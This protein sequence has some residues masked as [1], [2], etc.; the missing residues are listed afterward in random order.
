MK[1]SA[2]FA[3]AFVLTLGLAQCKKEQPNAQI[4]EGETVH[5]TVNVNN[6]G[7]RADVNTSTGHITFNDN[8][9]LYVG[10]N[11]AYVGTLDYSTS[12]SKFIGNIPLTEAAT[13]QKLHF[14][15]LGGGAA[16]QV[17][18]TQQYTVDI[19]D[20]TSNY[21]VI[22]YGT[23]TQ[24]YSASLNSYTTTLLNQCALVEFTT[25]EIPTT[26]AVSISGMKNKVTVDFNGNTLTPS[27]ERGTITL[28]NTESAISRWA[29]LLPDEEEVTSTASADGYNDSESFTVPAVNPN[30]YLAGESAVSISLTAAPST[31][32]GAINGLFSVSATQQVY[33]SKGNLQYIG[34][35]ATP[36]WQFAENQWDYLGTTTNQ[37]SADQNVDRDLF[38]WG[39]SGYNHGATAYQPWSTSKTNSDYY[40]YGSYTYNLY[41]QTGQADWGYNAISNGG[42]TENS[43]WRTLTQPEWDYV[44]NTRTTTSGIRYAK[45]RVNGKNG[46]IL[47]PDDWDA[48]TYDLNNTNSSGANFT[49]STITAADWT[50]TLEAN[51]AV[52]LPAAG[53]RS[54]SLVGVAAN[55]NGFYW[56]ASYYD[57]KQAYNLYFNT[58]NLYTDN[59]T[60]N[61][62]RYYGVSV[63]LV[64]NVE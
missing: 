9:K 39:T 38:G 35:A 21:P 34:S 46:V 30:D 20:Q 45:A 48:S 7:S 3:A 29:I 63:R 16:T 12:D 36:Y 28:H 40:A 44:F 37:N 1:K 54:G 61:T 6:N 42:N 25:N 49:S 62:N 56:S 50:N 27:E 11:N 51:G 31:P 53:Y 15:Y 13:A 19:S 22:S 43:G 33:F 47:L 64:R 55:N 58:S 60:T 4:T 57:S 18:T 17:G 8:D 26:T 32:V 59:N 52:F 2:I 24:N 10:Y 23:S 41:D 14:Y 5:I